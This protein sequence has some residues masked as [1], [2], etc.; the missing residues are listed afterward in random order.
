M[1]DVL[2][3]IVIRVICYPAGWAFIKVVIVGRRPV[4]RRLLGNQGRFTAYFQR[5][6]LSAHHR[7]LARYLKLISFKHLQAE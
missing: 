6:A 5:Y 2:L 7:D 1:L 3:E 4:I